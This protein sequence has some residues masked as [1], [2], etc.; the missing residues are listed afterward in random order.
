M[1]DNLCIYWRFNEVQA[2]KVLDASGLNNFGSLVDGGNV[3]ARSLVPR[4]PISDE[5]EWGEKVM[6]G[7]ALSGEVSIGSI[8]GLGDLGS[9]TIEAFIRRMS[10]VP[11]DS[12][13]YVLLT[14]CSTV[15]V[16]LNAAGFLVLDAGGTSYG[17]NKKLPLHQ[18]VHVALVCEKN[19][20]SVLVD[21]FPSFS[22]IK[23]PQ[24]TH[25]PASL[26]IGSSVCEFTEVRLWSIARLA[27]S[28]R[29]FMGIPLPQSA[30][31][32]SRW[33]GLRIKT[34]GQFNSSGLVRSTTFL[35]AL[36]GLGIKSRRILK[37]E[38]EEI[39]S[40][41]QNTTILLNSAPMMDEK[42]NAGDRPVSPLS[43]PVPQV[44][45][46]APHDHEFQRE[47]EIF[48][49]VQAAT[50]P[51]EIA[52]ILPQTLPVVPAELELALEVFDSMLEEALLN[53]LPYRSVDKK[54]LAKIILIISGYI[55]S[56][57]RVG[58]FL[59]PMPPESILSRLR[60]ACTYFGLASLVANSHQECW[61]SLILLRLPL[62]PRHVTEITLQCIQ[63]ARD[64]RDRRTAM[65]LSR[66]LIE[67]MKN[68]LS[69]T[70]FANAETECAAMHSIPPLTLIACPF[71][72]TLFEDPLQE[73]CNKGC[74]TKFTVCFL[75]GRCFPVDVSIKCRLCLSVMSNKRPVLMP[76]RNVPTTH[77][78][79]L[80]ES[81]PI[82]SVFG[83][84]QP[85]K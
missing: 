41:P 69:E 14:F 15:K 61:G 36:E 34:D 79:G 6:M 30:V 54:K 57:Y 38:D 66:R 58:P 47:H 60:I 75:Q 83:T 22:G 48:L 56:K 45:G 13:G 85:M 29:E 32:G 28:I 55:K 17:V 11:A 37:E 44:S 68:E 63:E 62:L 7:H 42:P 10:G 16:I 9:F 65:L 46:E 73:S 24:I 5:N 64:N 12:S 27:S 82:C 67:S 25:L 23:L 51:P 18:W 70:D 52:N 8:A 49:R 50:T 35:S 26:R 72:Q 84:L 33:K 43:A 31:S 1:I 71:C 39:I 20:V 21:G 40:V 77:V 76:S 81:C 80:P 74:H 19:E 59:V 3:S 4:D 53:S 2:S 78:M